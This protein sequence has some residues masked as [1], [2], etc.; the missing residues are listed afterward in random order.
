[1]FP[2]VII[3]VPPLNTPVRLA[4]PPAAIEVGL[5]AKLVI[6]GVA[7]TSGFTVTVASWAIVPPSEFVTASVYVVVEDGE[8]FTAAP[9]VAA[10]FPGIIMPVPPLNTPVR[11]AVPPAAIEVGLAAKLVIAGAVGTSGFT[12]TVASWAVVPLAGFVTVSV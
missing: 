5:A 9:L 12:V 2:G 4:D 11:L 8:T 10:M 6:V 1:M 3:P 7:G